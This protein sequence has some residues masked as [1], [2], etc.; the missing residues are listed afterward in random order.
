MPLYPSPIKNGDSYTIVELKQMT[1][2]STSLASDSRPFYHIVWTFR[3]APTHMNASSR[4][5]LIIVHKLI[6]GS[7]VSGQII[8]QHQCI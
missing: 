2:L 1:I 3:N 4:T 5:L 6:D 8:L 7:S